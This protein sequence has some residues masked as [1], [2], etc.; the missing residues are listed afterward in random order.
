MNFNERVSRSIRERGDLKSNLKKNV[1]VF[2][3]PL[4]GFGFLDLI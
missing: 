1:V 4:R 2:V 3:L